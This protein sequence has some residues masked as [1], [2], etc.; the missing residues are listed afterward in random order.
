MQRTLEQR[1][2][3]KFC[4][5]LGKT[6]AETLEMLRQAYAK[7]ALSSAQVFRWHKAFKNGRENVEDEHPLTTIS[8]Q[9]VQRVKEVLNSDRRLSARMIDDI[10]KLPKT[11]VH[12]IISENVH[13]RKIC[14]EF[15][16]KVLT[17][18]KKKFVSRFHAN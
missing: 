15:V 16:P 8:D 1:Y 11:I 4:V 7:E 18:D 10:V 6:G 13:M 12:E 17:A 14:A 9:N 2:A 3:I 5:K